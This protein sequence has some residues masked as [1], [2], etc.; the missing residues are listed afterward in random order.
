MALLPQLVHGSLLRD[1]FQVPC[2]QGTQVLPD[3]GSKP[4]LHRQS[5]CEALPGRLLFV[6]AGQTVQAADDSAMLLKVPI[7]QMVMLPPLPE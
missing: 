6:V 7:G 5:D 1:A 4:G 2:G 3:F